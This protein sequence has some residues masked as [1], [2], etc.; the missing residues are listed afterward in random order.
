VY[1]VTGK[2]GS[3]GSFFVA[4][5]LSKPE[6]RKIYLLNRKPEA[7]SIEERHQTA[8]RD[9][10]LDCDLLAQ[11]VHEGRAV[12]LEIALG[13]RNLGLNQQVYDGVRLFL[14]MTR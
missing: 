4:L 3:L 6:G 7:G 5:L 2:T 10:G 11:A 8:F 14:R 12:R 9:R 13:Q 1:A